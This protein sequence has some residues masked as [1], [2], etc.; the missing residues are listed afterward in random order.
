[1]KSGLRKRTTFAALMRAMVITAVL[2][3]MLPAGPV[4]AQ[5]TGLWIGQIE[6]DKVNEVGSR[7][8]TTTATQA[9]NPFD[10]RILVHSD[11]A[12]QVRM[13]REVTLMQKPYTVVEGG[14]TKEMVRRVLVTDD[15]L[16]SNYEGIVRRDGKLVGIRLGSAAFDFDSNMNDFPLTGTI[17]PGAS[18]TGTLVLAKTHPANPFRHKY[19]PDHRNDSDKGIEVTREF[20]MTFDQIPEGAEPEEGITSLKGTYQESVT[21]LHKIPI[22]AQGTFSLQRVSVI[23]KLNEG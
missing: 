7:T 9:P 5:E 23:D 1:M 17:S 22:R 19:H 20:T 3:R 21:G 4:T 11:A 18:V 15:S 6:I 8:D 13:L 2:M 12:G 16:L 10:M 14:E